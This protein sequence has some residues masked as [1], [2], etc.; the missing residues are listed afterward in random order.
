MLL[1]LF[2]KFTAPSQNYD[3]YLRKIVLN[4]SD[5]KLLANKVGSILYFVRI[6]ISTD[7]IIKHTCKHGF[8]KVLH[9]TNASKHLI[10]AYTNIYKV[11]N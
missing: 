5:L 4:E 1:N 9:V 2:A 6:D 11:H 7:V 3:I 10:D 8:S